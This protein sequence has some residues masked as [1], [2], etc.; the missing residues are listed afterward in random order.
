[1]RKIARVDS[2][3]TAIVATFRACGW[4]V[5]CTHQLGDGFPDIVVG[6]HGYNYLIEIKDGDRPQS[7]QKLT[8]DEAEFHS[9]WKGAIYI[10]R[11]IEEA[12]DFINKRVGE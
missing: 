9:E 4:S 10:I 1:M 8:K 6:K 5:H 2:N 11:S 12:L 3:Q 7:Q